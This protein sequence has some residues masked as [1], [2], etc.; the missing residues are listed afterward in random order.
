MAAQLTQPMRAYIASHPT[1]RVRALERDA[2]ARAYFGP[3]NY[4]M[5]EQGCLQV[6]DRRTAAPPAAVAAI[7]SP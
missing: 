4:D 1:Q 3:T 6:I 2:V 5:Y 7:S